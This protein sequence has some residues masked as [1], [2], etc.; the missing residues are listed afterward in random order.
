MWLS[1]RHKVAT[2]CTP[3]TCSRAHQYFSWTSEADVRGVLLSLL[4]LSTNTINLPFIDGD[5]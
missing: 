5:I 1:I 3:L 2:S 4:R